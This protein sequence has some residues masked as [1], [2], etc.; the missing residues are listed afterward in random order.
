MIEF[1]ARFGDPETEVVLPRLESDIYDFFNAA[2]DSTDFIPQWSHDAV[3]GVVMASKGYPGSYE[4]GAEIKGLENVKGEVFHMGTEKKDG[5][6]HVAG[7][8]VLM[9]IAHGED[10][11]EA[12]M[13]VKKEIALIECPALFHRN[14]IGK[15][16]FKA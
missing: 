12:N 6:F 10:L 3:I 1:N 9:I 4:K 16:A 11:P 8:R 2:I 7:G 15:A 5:K 13:N 14:D